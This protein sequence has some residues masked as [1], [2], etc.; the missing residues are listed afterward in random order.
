MQQTAGTIYGSSFSNRTT[1]RCLESRPR[2]VLELIKNSKEKLLK[3][4]KI[5]AYMLYI[6]NRKRF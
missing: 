6:E 1:C 3:I 4:P 2:S 5:S